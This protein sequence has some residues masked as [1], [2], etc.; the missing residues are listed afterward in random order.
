MSHSQACSARSKTEKRDSGC[1]PAWGRSQASAFTWVRCAGGKNG[2]STRPRSV[3]QGPACLTPAAAPFIDRRGPQATAATGF[4]MT[5]GGLFR[6]DE[7]E[8]R[9]QYRA[10]RGGRLVG[11][12]VGL[13]ELL[14]GE[15]GLVRAD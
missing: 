4:R 11:D 10:V 2:R 15:L 8:A 5:D 7:G 13:G 6:Q 14:G 1:L 12:F 3:L 9:P